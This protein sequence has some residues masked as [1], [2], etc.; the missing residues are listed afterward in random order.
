ME[1]V[2]LRV[3]L[4][5]PVHAV[6]DYLPVPGLDL[7]RMQPGMRV[8]VPFGH[9]RRVGVLLEVVRGS[10]VPRGKLKAALEILD[11]APLFSA[12]QIAF[13]LWVAGYYHHPVGEV[14]LAALPASG[15]R[16]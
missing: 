8:L 16:P 15:R 10:S 1:P 11:P 3:A 13:L 5:V 4:A 14:L 12:V 7:S 2:V 6:F 9:S